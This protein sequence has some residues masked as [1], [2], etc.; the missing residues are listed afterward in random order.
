MFPLLATG[1][2]VGMV[3]PALGP[4]RRG[5]PAVTLDVSHAALSGSDTL[6]MARLF[7]DRLRH[8]HLSDGI[9][10]TNRDEH[11]PCFATT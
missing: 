1:V 10:T 6:K 2:E 9:G 11:R 5:Y 3:L 4:S 7:G 8:L